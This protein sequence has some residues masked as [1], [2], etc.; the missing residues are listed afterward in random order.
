MIHDSRVRTLSEAPV[1]ER[2]Y[3]LYWM[4]ASQRERFNHA[5]EYAV[6]AADELG[7][8]VVAGFGLHEGFPEA[9]ARHFAFML[10][11][12]Q[13]TEAALR[14]RGIQLTVRKAPPDDAAIEFSHR[15]CM[16]VCD[17]GYLRHQRQWR[18]TLAAEA[19]CRVVQV[20]ADVVVP[21]AVTSEKEEYAA[22]TIRPKIHEHLDEYLVDLEQSGPERDSLE[23]GFN[24][25]DVSDWEAALARLDLDRSVAPVDAYVGGTSEAER[26]LD[27]FI[28][29][30][31]A[32][33]DERRNEP[34]DNWVSHVSPYM[35]FG[36]ISPVYVASEVAAHS[37]EGPEAY[38]EELIV[39]RELCINFCHYND[40]YD[41][42]EAL[43]EWALQTLAEHAGDERPYIYDAA[44][45]ERAETHDPYW[46][47]AQ[48]EMVL[49]G[50]M[51]NY[52]RMYW[53]KKIIE[54]T[55]EPSE[56]HALM[57]RLNN[58]YELDGRDPNSWGSFAWCMGK[59]D[60]PWQEREVFGKVRYMNA[61]GLERKFDIEAYVRKI[62][63]LSDQI[64]L[65]VQ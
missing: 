30:R 51:H 49:T 63:A 60:R 22:R 40:R 56:A 58:R 65:E 7:V 12:L 19:D 41:S 8:P 4:Q 14:E 13:E 36:Q 53:G 20:E 55:E 11:G 43:P 27:E 5:L 26:L 64:D 48:M 18:R 17:M 10:Q 45:L 39:R 54:W 25:A 16:V 6:R 21:V 33:Y 59:H 37:G 3:V 52:M 32:Q 62:D 31:L 35:H 42:T 44:A 1:R 57:A 38:L 50:K 2:E 24:S 23:I 61:A 28:G 46:N 34:A 47:A 29:E 15:A 9:N